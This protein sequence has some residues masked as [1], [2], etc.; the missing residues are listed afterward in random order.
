MK[1]ISVQALDAVAGEVLP[2]RTVLGTLPLSVGSDASSA[3]AA[4]SGGNSLIAPNHGSTVLSACSTDHKVPN[5][6]L[7]ELVGLHT[8][9]AS[10]IQTCTPSAVTS[11]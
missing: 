11:F 3:A 6:G 1:A 5:G 10:D 7:L 9:N 2:E 8:D 4:A